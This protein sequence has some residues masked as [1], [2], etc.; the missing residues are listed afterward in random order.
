MLRERCRNVRN[1]VS[2]G[3]IEIEYCPM[4][5]MQAD[6]MTKPLS[7]VNHAQL[8]KALNMVELQSQM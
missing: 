2:E 3:L 1:V 6:N 8:L 5:T 4:E 7:S